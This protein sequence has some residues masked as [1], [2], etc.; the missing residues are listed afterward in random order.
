MVG[1]GRIKHLVTC[2]CLS[3]KSSESTEM[4]SHFSIVHGDAEDRLDHGQLS[5][6]SL[7]S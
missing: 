3:C 1:E 7:S 2:C 4:L 5:C 6:F